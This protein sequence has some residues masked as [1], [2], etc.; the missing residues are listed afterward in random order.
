MTLKTFLKSLWNK[1]ENIFVRLP[2]EIKVALHIGILITENIKT[3]VDS[4]VAD[5]LTLLSPGNLDD[6][7]RD[8]LKLSIP[9]L[10]CDLKLAENTLN[11]TQPDEI[12][13]AAME[14]IKVMDENSKAGVPHQLSILIAQFAAD[15]KLGWS[16]GV[17]LSQWYYEQKFKTNT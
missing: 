9:T 14:T 10:L 12:I 13:K 5:I 4:P 8:K 1:I 3:F 16:D 2:N 6:I 11:L 15:G 17:Y 7:M